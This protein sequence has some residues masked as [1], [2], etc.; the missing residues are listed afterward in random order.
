MP[1]ERI[2]LDGS[3]LGGY[4]EAVLDPSTAVSVEVRGV[5]CVAELA[6]KRARMEVNDEAPELIS[7]YACLHDGTAT[8]IGDFPNAKEADSYADEIGQFYKL[9]VE[10]LPRALAA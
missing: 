3:S 9:P 4:A 8:C 5:V 10:H 1:H 6:Q 7:V 2:P